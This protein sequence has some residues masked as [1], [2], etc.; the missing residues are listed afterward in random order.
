[1]GEVYRARDGRLN[2]DVAIKILP[3]SFSSSGAQSVPS[4]CFSADGKSYVYSLGR[5]LSEL[6]CGRWV[7]VIVDGRTHSSA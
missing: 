6:V 1:M 4:L 7:E 3:A 2:R 5:M